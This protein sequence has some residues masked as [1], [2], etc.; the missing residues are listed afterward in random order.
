MNHQ[1]NETIKKQLNKKGWKPFR[2]TSP[3]NPH[4]TPS[5]PSPLP[6]KPPTMNNPF[7]LG[8]DQELTNLATDREDGLGIPLPDHPFADVMSLVAP[9]DQGAAGMVEELTQ[10]TK[11]LTPQQRETCSALVERGRQIHGG[12]FK[13]DFDQVYP[14]QQLKAIEDAL[15]NELNE[16]TAKGMAPK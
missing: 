14:M 15:P 9:K 6:P 11:P 2:A 12:D 5:H 1:S 7:L 13:A 16:T 8:F 4:L 10:S 3:P